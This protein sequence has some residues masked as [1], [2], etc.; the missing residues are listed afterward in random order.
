MT[1]PIAYFVMMI[2]KFSDYFGGTVW[3]IKK[4]IRGHKH[5]YPKT[6]QFIVKFLW[7]RF[8]LY[9]FIVLFPLFSS[10]LLGFSLSTKEYGFVLACILVVF[11][12]V[13]CGVFTIRKN[14][15]HEL[16]VIDIFNEAPVELLK[17]SKMTIIDGNELFY[18]A[19]NKCFLL[20]TDKFY[21]LQLSI[22]LDEYKELELIK[23]N[24]E[25]ELSIIEF[26]ISKSKAKE[27]KERLNKDKQGL[28]KFLKEIDETINSFDV[29]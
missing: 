12:T 17:N 11:F 28:S 16:V 19:N 20:K 13:Y 1:G 3:D 25:E 2:L 27:E 18:S 23:F 10:F 21:Q 5:L 6:R 15:S 26:V 14:Y 22:S 29:F 8:S 9:F 7:Y 24:I 4:S